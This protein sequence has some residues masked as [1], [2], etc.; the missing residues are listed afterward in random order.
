MGHGASNFVIA[1]KLYLNYLASH[2]LPKKQ[3]LKLPLRFSAVDVW[4]QFKLIPSGL[5]DDGPRTETIKALPVWKKADVA[6]YD[7][8]IVM[9]NDNAEA[10]SIKGM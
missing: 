4:H 5:F 6:H 9:D 7:T 8:V 10:V 3:A 1:L 2:P